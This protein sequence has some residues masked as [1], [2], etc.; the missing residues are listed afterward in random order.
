MPLFVPHK[1]LIEIM[2]YGGMEAADIDDMLVANRYNPLNPE[3]YE[4]ILSGVRTPAWEE[5]H[6][7]NA[8]IYAKNSSRKI[9]AN[10]RSAY[11][12]E[13]DFEAYYNPGAVYDIMTYMTGANRGTKGY[14]TSKTLKIFV[15]GRLRQFV[16]IATMVGL[17]AESIRHYL[18]QL[19]P[20]YGT[21][22]LTPVLT[23]TR[24]FWNATRLAMRQENVRHSDIRE[25][26][27]RD[28]DNMFYLPYLRYLDGSE[29]DVLAYFGLADFAV[30]QRKN[31]SLHGKIG[32]QIMDYFEEKTRRII[33]TDY[34]K[35][36]VHLDQQIHD[37][38]S[39]DKGMETYREEIRRIFDRLE[40]IKDSYRSMD[41]LNDMI[42]TIDPNTEKDEPYMK[43]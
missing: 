17:P 23:Y 43:D 20:S 8:E 3:I 29:E 35:L 13:G 38:E 14:G 11:Y 22:A 7:I 32:G 1:T 39:Q 34:V 37:L 26:I 25:Y 19:E 10:A 31:R 4:E 21:W 30:V 42:I 18:H 27:M 40:H 9:A 5:A 15:T 16:D 36:F 6:K 33:P 41:E 28:Q 12:A 2:W 24:I